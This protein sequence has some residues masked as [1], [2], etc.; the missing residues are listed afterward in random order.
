MGNKVLIPDNGV[1]VAKSAYDQTVNILADTAQPVT[2]TLPNGETYE[3]GELWVELRGQLL[4][5][6]ID[7]TF[8]GVAPRTQ[9]A[10]LQ[11]LFIGDTIRIR[12][13]S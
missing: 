6:G 7:Y 3:D 8:I 2:I 10:I 9:I 4:R 1:L 13:L 11:D 12:K 5:P